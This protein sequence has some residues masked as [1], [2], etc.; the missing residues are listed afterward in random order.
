MPKKKHNYE[1]VPVATTLERLQTLKK[2]CRGKKAEVGVVTR[3][4][5]RLIRRVNDLQPTK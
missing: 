5:S 3:D 1:A 4:N 2:F